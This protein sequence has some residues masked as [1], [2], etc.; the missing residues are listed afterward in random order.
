MPRLR[1][2]APRILPLNI[3]DLSRFA[4]AVVGTLV[5]VIVLVV[6]GNLI[7]D[8]DEPDQNAVS[9]TETAAPAA[10]AAA[11]P[12]PEAEAEPEATAEAAAEAEPEAE[13]EAQAEDQATAEAESAG[14][15][16]PEAESAAEA[17]SGPEA[18]GAGALAALLAKG[19]VEAGQR[20]ANR[21][22]SCHTFDEG[23]R[24]GIGPNLWGTLGSPR[25]ANADYKYS[26]ALTDLGG[27]WGYAEL[28]T[29][30]EKPKSAVPGTKMSFAGIRDAQDRANV[31][32]YLRSVSD[33]E[34]PLPLAGE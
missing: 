13:E 8:V 7:F 17:E 25:A 16:E 21:C 23:G 6:I 11:T 28:D 20:T 33:V 5:L 29:F 4:A 1:R 14:E 27:D 26:G 34:L 19:S 22:R 9:E 15:A 12:E 30:L 18:G 2:P 31:I 3:F 32:L 10:T 24:N